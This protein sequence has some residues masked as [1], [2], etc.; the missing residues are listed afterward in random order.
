[1][2]EVHHV[3]FH[4]IVQAYFWFLHGS[5]GAYKILQYQTNETEVKS[6]DPK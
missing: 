4:L 6:N 3:L 5:L 1:M 2:F